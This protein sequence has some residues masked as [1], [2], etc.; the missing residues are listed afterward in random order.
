MIERCVKVWSNPGELVY[1]PFAGV[2]S[3]GVVALR[4]GRR[5]VG[6]ELKREY[7]QTARHNLEMVAAQP[8]MIE[9]TA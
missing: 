2:G 7:W 5:F 4:E 3:E 6:G 8:R 9:I 1:S